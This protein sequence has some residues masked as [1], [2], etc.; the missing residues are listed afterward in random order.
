MPTW[1]K[2]LQLLQIKSC[3]IKQISDILK[4]SADKLDADLEKLRQSQFVLMSPQRQDEKIV[5]MFEILPEGIKELDRTE[6]RGFDK[7]KLGE[8]EP[9]KEIL[10]TIDEVIADIQGTEI[11]QAKKG[12]ITKKL[13]SL[14]ERLEI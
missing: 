3:S 6:A 5:K 14:K 8:A 9:E 13:S 1:A 10:S 12:Q 7:T 2:I 4:I 11:T